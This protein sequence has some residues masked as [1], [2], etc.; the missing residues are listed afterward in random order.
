MERKEK[1]QGICSQSNLCSCVALETQPFRL[2]ECG[3][4][5]NQTKHLNCHCHSPIFLLYFKWHKQLPRIHP[6]YKPNTLRVKILVML[7]NGSLL[8]DFFKQTQGSSLSVR[9]KPTALFSFPYKNKTEK[10]NA[11]HYLTA[12]LGTKWLWVGT[13]KLGM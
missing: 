3:K 8:K 6:I 10:K 11:T 13:L 4:K 12:A 1:D 5:T 9:V 7:Q 2:K